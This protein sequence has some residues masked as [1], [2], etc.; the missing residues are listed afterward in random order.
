MRV[1]SFIAVSASFLELTATLVTVA[2]VM[3]SGLYRLNGYFFVDALGA[4]I[5]MLVA[6][7]GAMASWY[8]T[9][10]LKLEVAK[11]IIGFSRVRQY[12]IL[13]HL[14]LLA[15]FFASYVHEP[16]FDLDCD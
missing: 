13:L 11:R 7:V 8:S 12:F 5:I 2:S 15:M 4:V 16:H 3:D 9:G 6:V 10:Y 14:F 1:L